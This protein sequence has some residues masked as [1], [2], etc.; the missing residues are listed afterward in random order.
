MPSF[1]DEIVQLCISPLKLLP[2]SKMDLG[3]TFSTQGK[4]YSKEG[5]PEWVPPHFRKVIS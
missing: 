2:Y 5:I 1:H 3:K 4:Q